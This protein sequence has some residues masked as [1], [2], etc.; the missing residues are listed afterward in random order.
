MTRAERGHS[1]KDELRDAANFDFRPR[2]GSSLIDTGTHKIG[3]TDGFI[4]AAPDIGPYEYGDDYY[5]I[6]GHKTE[7]AKSPIPMDGAASA[8]PNTDLIWLEGLEMS[9]NKV[10]FGSD[11]DKLDLQATQVSNI[12]MPQ[13]TLIPGETYHWRVDTVAD[14]R[15]VPGDV[16]S[17]TV[18]PATGPTDLALSTTELNSVAGQDDVLATLSTT[19]PDSVDSHTYSLVEG[20]GDTSNGLFSINNCLL[21]TSDAADD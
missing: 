13:Q 9:T 2:F 1:I 14:D 8:K 15:V 6:P 4:G 17:F 18:G 5:W 21:Y 19:D 10:Y 20:T 3:F 11:S 7:D 12:F 16:W